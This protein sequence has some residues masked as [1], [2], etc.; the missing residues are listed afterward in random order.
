[1]KK[2]GLMIAMMTLV[3]N[4]AAAYCVQT[5]M[6]CKRDFTGNLS[7]IQMCSTQNCPFT[8]QIEIR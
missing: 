3:G 4:V 5:K 7:C 2:L 8:H 1:M 6:C